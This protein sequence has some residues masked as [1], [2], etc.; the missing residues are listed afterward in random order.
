MLAGVEILLEIYEI[1]KHHAQNLLIYINYQKESSFILGIAFQAFKLS[2]L[3]RVSSS[4]SSCDYP[5]IQR[6]FKDGKK[7]T[8]IL[9]KMLKYFS[10][11]YDEFRDKTIS[12]F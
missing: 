11:N 9:R 1:T 8:K 6:L 3:L 2:I 5:C 10:R 4:Y 12:V 7:K